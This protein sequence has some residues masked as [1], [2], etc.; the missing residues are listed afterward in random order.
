MK[1]NAGFEY[2][3]RAGT[4]NRKREEGRFEKKQGEFCFVSTSVANKSAVQY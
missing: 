2:G 4:A 1:R 3:R